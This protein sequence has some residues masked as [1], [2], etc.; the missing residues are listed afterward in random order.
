MHNGIANTAIISVFALVLLLLRPSFHSSYSSSRSHSSH[1]GPARCGAAVA[2]P[3]QPSTSNLA[4]ATMPPRVDPVCAAADKHIHEFAAGLDERLRP[5]CSRAQLED[6]QT[7]RINSELEA[8][9]ISYVADKIHRG[10]KMTETAVIAHLS[11][12]SGAVTRIKSHIE[13]HLRGTGGKPLA[14]SKATANLNDGFG[15]FQGYDDKEE[16]DEAIAQIEE[17]VRDGKVKGMSR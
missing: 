5:L 8:R 2:L 10:L 15:P 11:A 6:H 16:R 17:M 3:E 9:M 12:P 1:P 4:I 13:R 7:N 14:S